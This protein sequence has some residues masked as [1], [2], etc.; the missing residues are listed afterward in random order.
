MS[1]DNVIKFPVSPEQQEADERA[2]FFFV[3]SVYF[4]QNFMELFKDNPSPLPMLI[5][6]L[7]LTEVVDYHIQEG[8]AFIKDNDGPILQ[9]AMIEGLHEE[10][11][12]GMA[13]LAAHH[14]EERT[15]NDIH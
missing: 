3:M 4:A 8:N 13:E 12:E 7:T 1:D 6:L 14:N 15:E 5:S 11:S 2:D 10:L 9:L